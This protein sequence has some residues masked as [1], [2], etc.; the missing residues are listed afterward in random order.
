MG[1]K[2]TEVTDKIR[3]LMNPADAELYGG[4]PM[5][6]ADPPAKT[7]RLEREDQRQFASY[8]LLHNYAPVW[9]STAHRSKASLGCPDFF[10]TVNG[11]PL[12]L[13]FKRIGGKLSAVQED[14]S[15]RHLNNGGLYFVVYSANEAIQVCEKYARKERL[16]FGDRYP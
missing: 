12:M 11:Y 13:E 15:A 2:I 6:L 4:G 10:V 8:C 9:H 5:Q 14:W 7:D 3:S 16:T 1:I